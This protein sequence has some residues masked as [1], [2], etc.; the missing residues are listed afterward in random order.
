MTVCVNYNCRYAQPYIF[1]VFLIFNVLS[2]VLQLLWRQNM[3]QIGWIML[4]FCH[5]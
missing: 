5:W 4:S 2:V 3:S 1:N